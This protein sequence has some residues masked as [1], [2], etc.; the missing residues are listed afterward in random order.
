MK[1]LAFKIKNGKVSELLQKL[2]FEFG[3]KCN[4]FNWEQK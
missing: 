4:R 2:L 1:N 3:Y